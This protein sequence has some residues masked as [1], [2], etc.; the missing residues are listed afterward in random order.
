MG[1]EGEHLVAVYLIAF[2][3]DGETAVAVAVEGEAE[4]EMLVD[5]ELAELL[6]MGAAAV[7]VDVSVVIFTTVDELDFGAEGFEDLG[8]NGTGGAVGA[9]HAEVETRE[10]LGGG[11][12]TMNGRGRG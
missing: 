8:T 11:G 9:I 10:K 4:I 6:E 2:G 3:I 7:L 12:R 1:E 5:D